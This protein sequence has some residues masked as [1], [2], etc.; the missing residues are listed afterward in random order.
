MS[1]SNEINPVHVY[2]SPGKYSVTLTAYNQE[3]IVIK[4]VA[5]VIDVRH[6]LPLVEA[7]V[8]IFEGIA[9]LEVI[10]TSMP[11]NVV[12]YLWSFGDGSTSDLQSP[13]HLYQKPG[14]YTVK[15]IGYNAD[16]EMK[17]YTLSKQIIA[18]YPSATANFEAIPMAGVS[19]L[20]VK[21]NNKSANG[22]KF[23]WNFGD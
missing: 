21:F 2:Q 23:E 5:Q 11:T 6:P 7:T 18:H 1:I 17:E 9:P 15:V 12:R 8:S 13:A 20:T 22:V 10:F 4:S 16:G 19:P 14:N 3:G